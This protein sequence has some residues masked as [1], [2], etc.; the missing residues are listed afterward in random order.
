MQRLTRA[1]GLV[2]AAAAAAICGCQ[3]APPPE[4][5]TTAEV[6][7]LSAE[8]KAPEEVI[9]EIRR[10][11]TVYLLR[12]RDV[13]D[14]LEKGVDERVVDFM[15]ETRI[16]DLERRWAYYWYPYPYYYPWWGPHVHFGYYWSP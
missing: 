3:S 9:A 14:L 16:R 5:L 7:A 10:S 4:P 12:A 1:I 15:L 2:T 11:R 8:G 13:R 6:I